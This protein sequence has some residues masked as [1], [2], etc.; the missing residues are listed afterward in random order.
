MAGVP[1]NILLVR[2]FSRT[3]LVDCSSDNRMYSIGI[4]TTRTLA[5]IIVMV[6]KIVGPMLRQLQQIYTASE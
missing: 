2:S 4:T 5:I 3:V 1:G 6:L